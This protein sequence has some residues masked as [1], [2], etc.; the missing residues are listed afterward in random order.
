[1]TSI[2]FYL[3]HIPLVIIR[4]KKYSKQVYLSIF[5]G[6][7]DVFTTVNQLVGMHTSKNVGETQRKRAEKSVLNISFAIQNILQTFPNNL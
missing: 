7:W 5:V 1:M 3:Q 4:I 2:T 6:H